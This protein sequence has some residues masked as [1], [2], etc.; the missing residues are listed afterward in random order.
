MK[1]SMDNWP[2]DG[3]DNPLKVVE[4]CSEECCADWLVQIEKVNGPI[5]LQSIRAGRDLYKETGGKPFKYCPWCG[6]VRPK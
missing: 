4:D 6:K 1:E 2:T 3:P 5:V